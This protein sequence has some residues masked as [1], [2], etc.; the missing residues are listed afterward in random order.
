MGDRGRG[1]WSHDSS[2]RCLWEIGGVATGHMILVVGVHED[3]GHGHWSH[4]FSIS[5]TLD[6]VTILYIL[7]RKIIAPI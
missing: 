5:Y 1:H 2:G 7:V 4:D 3:R 6:R